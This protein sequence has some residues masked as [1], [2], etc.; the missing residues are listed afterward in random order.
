MLRL[1]F[2]LPLLLAAC[3]KDET[4]SGFTD[5]SANYALAELDGLRFAARATISFPQEGQVKG[6]GPCNGY[7][8][9][10]TVPYPWFQLSAVRATRRACPDLPREAEF[11][12][13][14]NEMTLIEASGD[15]LILRNEA[16]REMVFRAV[17]P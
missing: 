14:L 16:G 7:S 5:P 11:F 3:P 4:I 2:F 12:A 8:A 15:T 6:S 13:A 9:E 17:Q 1:A 10:Q